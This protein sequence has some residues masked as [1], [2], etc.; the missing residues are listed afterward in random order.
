MKDKSSGGDLIKKVV[1]EGLMSP[2]LAPQV[3]ADVL[4]AE[5]SKHAAEIEK[6]LNKSYQQYAERYHNLK[7]HTWVIKQEKI[8]RFDL[9]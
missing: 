7:T 2:H 4:I 6:L 9:S 5:I 3:R 8:A 1:S